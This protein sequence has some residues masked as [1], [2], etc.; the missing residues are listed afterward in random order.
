MQPVTPRTFLLAAAAGLI[1]AASPVMG[2]AGAL[3]APVKAKAADEKIHITSDYMKYDRKAKVALATGNV[4][5]VQEDTT[6]RTAEVQFDQGQKIS[7]MNQP[8]KVVQ[9]KVKEPRTTLDSQ[10]MTNFHKDKRIIAEGAVKMVRAKDPFAKPTGS[11]QKD[12]VAVAIKKQDTVITADKLEYWTQ[13]KNAHFTGN[14]VIINDQKK[15]WGD[16]AFMDQ[17]K[18]TVT[19]D[20][21]V[22]VVQINGNWL[23]KEKIVKADSPDEARDEALRER[24]TLT[25]DNLVIDQRTNDAVATG[26][27]VRVEQKG[28]VATGRKAVFS[29]KNSMITMTDNVRI[30]QTNGDWLT[31]TKA[32]FHT[33]TE[34]F[35][36][37]SG[38][39]TQVQTEF[40]VPE[41]KPKPDKGRVEMEFDVN[42][43]EK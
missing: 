30:Q 32:V 4:V 37:F 18:N 36:A 38:G 6:I 42:E 40:E 41:Q 3:A 29:D 19:L 8:V 10:R 15:S 13:A 39:S 35:E 2:T 25:C 11:A 7:Y 1:L 22:R 12:K 20:G 5:I 43:T 16:K 17:A 27:I 26:Q 14:V 24:A 21:R 9:Q 23:V 33:N 31:A 28:K 34:V